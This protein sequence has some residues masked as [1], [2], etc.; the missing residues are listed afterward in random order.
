[1]YITSKLYD[2]IEGWIKEAIKSNVTR[3]Y[4]QMHTLEGR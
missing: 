3:N 1:M 2:V 4:L